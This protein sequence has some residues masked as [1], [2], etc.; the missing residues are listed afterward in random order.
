[1][2]MYRI[3]HSKEWYILESMPPE[4][5]ACMLSRIKT[6][7]LTPAHQYAHVPIETHVHALTRVLFSAHGAK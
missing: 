5:G 6:L 2:C 3:H 4:G 7:S 1:M